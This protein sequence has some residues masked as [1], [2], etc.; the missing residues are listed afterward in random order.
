MDTL[1]EQFARA[2]AHKDWDTVR[3]L[4]TDDVDFRAL[5]P[6]RFWEA[7]T[8]DEVV[9]GALRVWIDESE[10]VTS[11]LSVDTDRVVDRARVG[12]RFRVA[13]D[14]G[15]TDLEQQVYY[16]TAGGRISWMRIVCSGNRRVGPRS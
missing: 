10:H 2:F 11:V 7:N 15:E 13:S 3:N 16:E 5:T 6:R 12:Y 14:V 4:L 1:G 8:P 9:E